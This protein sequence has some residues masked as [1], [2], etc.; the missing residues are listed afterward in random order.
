[1]AIFLCEGLVRDEHYFIRTHTANYYRRERHQHHHQHQT[2][3]I[4]MGISHISKCC[5]TIRAIRS[6]TLLYFGGC[7]AAAPCH[8]MY[9]FRRWEYVTSNEFIQRPKFDQIQSKFVG[10]IHSP[11]LIVCMI[12]TRINGGQLLLEVDQ[13]LDELHTQYSRN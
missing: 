10:S 12:E 8:T 4:D 13:I 11:A 2:I 7:P 3:S 1:M 6:I 9:M 5:H